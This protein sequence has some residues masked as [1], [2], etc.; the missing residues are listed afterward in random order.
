MSDFALFAQRIGL[1]G[2]VSLLSSLSA[3][4]LLPVLTKNMPLDD[5]GI[6]T[7]VNVTLGLVSTLM[8][9]GLPDALTRF[10]AASR[11]REETQERFWTIFCMILLW[12]SSVALILFYCSETLAGFLFHGNLAVARMVP[13]IVLVHSLNILMTYLFRTVQQMKNYS[14]F[15]LLS[16]VLD[17]VLVSAFVLTGHGI[18]G[19]VQALLLSKALQF[20]TML[21]LIVYRIGVN[22]PR[23]E[24]VRDYL[25]F[26]LPMVPSIFSSWVV[27]S[28][29]RYVINL[30][31]GTAAVAVYSPGY[32]LGNV[33]GMFVGPIMLVLP[34]DLSKHYDNNRSDLV[35]TILSRSLKYYLAVAIP[36]FFG[37]TLLSRPILLVLST[38]DIADQ[39]YIITPFIAASMILYGISTILSNVLSLQKKTVHIGLIW[40]GAAVLNLVMTVLLVRG[41]GIIGGA[42][43]TLVA[44]TFIFSMMFRLSSPDLRP[45][46]D[47]IF[48]SKCLAASLLMSAV[49][50]AWTPSSALDILAEI[51]ICAAV[52]FLI[53][54]ILGG[55]ERSEINFLKDIL[56]KKN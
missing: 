24:D 51:V 37:L 29:D 53:L 11:N 34:V 23:F 43:A 3:M 54:Y 21:S 8:L 50:L 32:I 2:L 52:Y 46:V 56:L 39:G 6:W 4:V 14:F 38:R 45:S 25:K 26:G 1:V 30:L 31:L 27:N 48:L 7:Q 20:L 47:R 41:L 55:V 22:V 17:L 28:S 36:S 19:A 13:L 10:A 42:I 40:M 5:F 44:F 15:S 12:G 18:D 35:E 9:L 49:T 16:L 33:A